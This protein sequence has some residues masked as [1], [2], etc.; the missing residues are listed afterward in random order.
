M[1]GN[2]VA[3]AAAFA[4]A[5]YV[6]AKLLEYYGV[7]ADRYGPYLLFLVFLAVSGLVLPRDYPGVIK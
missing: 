2:T 7:G 3:Q 1:D 4:V 6:A 5:A